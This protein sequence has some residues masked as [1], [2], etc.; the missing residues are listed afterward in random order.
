MSEEEAAL[1]DLCIELQRHKGV[2]DVTYERAL[3]ALGGEAKIVEA[4]AIQGYYSLLAMVMN[5]ARTPLGK[6]A[7]PVL[8]LLPQR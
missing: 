7:T 6:T 1:Y 8:P 3:K 2:S 5:V 4:V